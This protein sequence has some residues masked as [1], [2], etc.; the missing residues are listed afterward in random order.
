MYS[1]TPT[2]RPPLLSQFVLAPLRFFFISND[3]T[4][5]CVTQD[6]F[7]TNS[8]RIKHFTFPRWRGGWVMFRKLVFPSSLFLGVAFSFVLR[9]L[10]LPL[11]LLLSPSFNSNPVLLRVSARGACL[12][13]NGPF[14]ELN[15]RPI[16][17]ASSSQR[18][19]RER[20]KREKRKGIPCNSNSDKD[21][22]APN[23]L[24]PEAAARRGMHGGRQRTQEAIG[25][26]MAWLGD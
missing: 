9:P 15:F 16:L 3:C 2:S 26:G 12:H 22:F 20:E 13:F 21:H 4:E 23:P 17:P 25:L 10:S 19:K 6:R 7:F 14:R 1:Y 11:F 24:F 8:V 5:R 18:E